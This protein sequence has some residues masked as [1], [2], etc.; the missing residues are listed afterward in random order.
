MEE[1]FLIHEGGIINPK[2][3]I[4]PLL[5]TCFPF[6]GFAINHVLEGLTNGRIVVLGVKTWT[7]C[8]GIA[9]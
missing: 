6:S 1:R 3:Q 2:L 5:P 8:L 4:A 9:T 7:I